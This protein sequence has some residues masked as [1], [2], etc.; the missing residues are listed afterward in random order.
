[1]RKRYPRAVDRAVVGHVGHPSE[2]LL[3]HIFQ[4]AIDTVAGAIDPS[5]AGLQ[6]L[7]AS[8]GAASAQILEFEIGALSASMKKDYAKAIELMIKARQR[9][10]SNRCPTSQTRS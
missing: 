2:L 9:S 4:A 3:R 5:I 6:S 7:R 10:A 8:R 1:M